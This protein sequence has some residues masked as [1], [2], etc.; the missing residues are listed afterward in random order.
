MSW[1]GRALLAALMAALHLVLLGAILAA[2]GRQPGLR[3]DAPIFLSL[4][5]GVRNARSPAA[6]ALPPRAVSQEPFLKPLS[7]PVP[8]DI[9]LPAPIAEAAPISRAANPQSLVQAAS[10]EG[11]APASAGGAVDCGMLQAL[12]LRL[13]GDADALKALSSI[14]HLARSVANAVQ[15]WDGDWA[16]AG[17]LGGEGVLGPIRSAVVQTVRAASE[18]C[19]MQQVRGPRLIAAPD[20]AGSII[21]SVGSGVWAWKDLVVNKTAAE[22]KP[23]E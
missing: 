6:S 12:Q 13:R 9:A 10:G 22:A 21:V 17:P 8:A 18:A 20:G 3:P 1:T 11:P 15:L 23:P 7:V 14:P 16:S 2:P 5:R 19:Q 4:E